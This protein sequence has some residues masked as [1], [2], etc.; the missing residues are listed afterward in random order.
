MRVLRVSDRFK[1]VPQAGS[2]AVSTPGTYRETIPLEIIAPRAGLTTTN[3]YY[4]AYPG[5]LYD[6]QIS[7]IGGIYPYTY[8]L[9][10]APSGMTVDSSTGIITWSS[11]PASGTP[12]DVTAAVTD[13]DGTT[14]TVSWTITVTTSG[15][16]FID[17]VNGKT[18]AGG[19]TGTFANPWKEIDDWYLGSWADSTYSGSFLYWRTGTYAPEDSSGVNSTYLSFSSYKPLVWLAYPGDSPV[20][21]FATRYINVSSVDNFYIDG[22]EGTPFSNG[23]G[24][25]PYGIN[26]S[27]LSNDIVFRNLNFHNMTTG[28]IGWNSSMIFA[29]ANA[30]LGKYWTI[31]DNTFSNVAFPGYGVL[32]YCCEKIAVDRNTCTDFTDS[33][34]H[35]IGPKEATS[36]WFIRDN[37][38]DIAAG[39]AIW[40]F[41]AERDGGNL[42]TT[43]DMEVCY[44]R[45][46]SGG[47]AFWAGQSSALSM[48]LLNMRRNTLEGTVLFSRLRTDVTGPAYFDRDVIIN[49]TSGIT[50]GDSTA[51]AIA[52][53]LLTGN[54][55]DAI[56]DSNGHLTA[57]YSAYLGT[58]GH[59][60][61]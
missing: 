60:R 10:T 44:N 57:S 5:L 14:V 6:V 61:T 4:K 25:G 47:N 28:G 40:I 2:G 48:G 13:S 17:A 37:D 8:S 52:S 19:G 50:Y 7:A 58:H 22:F 12:Y 9:T 45:V 49:S 16:Y 1:G 21:N 3:R 46:K 30:G 18:V 42:R 43:F 11:P 15:F 51:T 38:I 26:I 41:G 35:V 56:V 36:K 55:A 54:A 24:T 23:S 34:C 53:D 59:Q 27:S 20:L 32:G 33:S 29:T 39:D 31:I